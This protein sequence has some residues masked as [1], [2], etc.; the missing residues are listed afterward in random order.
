MVEEWRHIES[1]S[2]WANMSLGTEVEEWHMLGCFREAVSIARTSMTW[3]FIPYGQVS[4]SL[5]FVSLFSY[6]LADN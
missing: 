5:W 6:F 4:A 1:A 2:S 3:D